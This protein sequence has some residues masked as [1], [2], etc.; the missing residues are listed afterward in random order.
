MTDQRRP[1]DAE[2]IHQGKDHLAL[3]QQRTIERVS[4]IRHTMADE[5]RRDHT[6]MFG[7][8]IDHFMVEERPCGDAVHQNDGIALADV[9]VGN[10]D[11][12]VGDA[13]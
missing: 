3:C 10:R 1:F 9:R 7:Q 6:V 8:L 13:V 2:V 12:M 11:R 4:L 5:I